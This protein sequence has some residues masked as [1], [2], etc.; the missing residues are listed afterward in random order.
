MELFEEKRTKVIVKFIVL[1]NILQDGRKV[2]TRLL[3][4]LYKKWEGN[5]F[6]DQ[7]KLIL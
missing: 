3:S 2:H 1:S 4:D 7:E 5:Q 6:L